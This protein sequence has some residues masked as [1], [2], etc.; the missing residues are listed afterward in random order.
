MRRRSSTGSR[1]A[2]AVARSPAAFIACTYVLVGSSVIAVGMLDLWMAL[3]AA[4]G[5]VALVL[6]ALAA[7][8][9]T[10]QLARG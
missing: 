6:I 7:V 8:A 2:S 9:S 5:A 3:S 1:L 10:W 4:V